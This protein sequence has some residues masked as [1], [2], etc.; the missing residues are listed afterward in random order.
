[1]WTRE[2]EQLMHLS[3][4]FWSTGSCSIKATLMSACSHLS[5]IKHPHSIIE[6]SLQTFKQPFSSR[7]THTTRLVS[8]FPTFIPK[9]S[10][11]DKAYAEMM[12]KLP[13][14][15]RSKHGHKCEGT[16]STLVCGHKAPVQVKRHPAC[17]ICAET[18]PALCQPTY[19]KAVESSKRCGPCQAE[20]GKKARE[21]GQRK[22]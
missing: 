3:I 7:A 20:H 15:Q 18:A 17:Y 21:R 13:E 4:V 1:M 14:S 22:K 8:K 12:R 19:P 5:I 11:V 2:P 6:I 16:Y 9:M 10:R